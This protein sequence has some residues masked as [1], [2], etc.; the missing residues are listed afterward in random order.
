MK[1]YK[2]WIIILIAILSLVIYFAIEDKKKKDRGTEVATEAVQIRDIIETVTASGKIYAEEEVKISSDVSGEI[3]ELYVKEGDFVQKGQLL[4]KIQPES[5]QAYVEQA[6]ASL[7][8][9][10]ATFK[11]SQAQLSNLKA[12]EKQVQAQYENAKDNYD[13]AQLLFNDNNISKAELDQS[14]TAYRTALAEVEAAKEGIKGAQYSIEGTQAQI[15]A[16]QAQ[17]KEAKNNLSKTTI[18]APMS[19]T[20]SVLNVE[21]GEKVVGTLQMSGTEILRISNLSGMEVRVDVS[22]N[23][24][25][26][27]QRGDTAAVEVDAYLGRKFMGI[28]TEVAYS[29]K[30]MSSTLGSISNDQSTNFIIKVRILPESYADLSTQKEDPFLP[31]MSATVEV[32]TD[33]V[34][35]VIAVPVQA[36]TTRDKLDSKDQQE[37][38]FIAKD[39]KAQ[40]VAIQTGI[41]DDTYIQII[42]GLAK[43][44]K[45]ITAPYSLLSKTIKD[46]D[47]ITVVDKDKLKAIIEEEEEEK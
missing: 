32:K 8:G 34:R 26:K 4:A 16:S 15:K 14:K 3:V 1:K 31:G 41:Q 38:V 10:I 21:K 25:I 23:E 39:K 44:S 28:V 30:G 18:Y 27:I 45:I 46:G 20:I 6:D 43:D 19:G 33:I 29:S 24:V 42:G 2:W 40:Q 22:E 17:I 35:N 12:R 13:R 47:K 7:N 11:N 5:Y 9:A 37:V 36:V